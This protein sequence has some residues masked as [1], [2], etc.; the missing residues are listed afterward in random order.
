MGKVLTPEQQIDELRKLASPRLFRVL[1]LSL[2]SVGIVLLL[3]ASLYQIPIAAIF[4]GF[5]SFVS[6]AARWIQP[7]LH[8]AIKAWEKKDTVEG[9]IEIKKVYDSDHYTGTGQVRD[10]TWEFYFY[11][12]MNWEPEE[13]SYAAKF[14]FDGQNPW[15][16]LILLNDGILYPR[17]KPKRAKV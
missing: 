13:K 7:F 1:S 4:G 8:N 15:P 11:R 6:F 12:P 16:S 3:I 17:S 10:N 2:L 9:T 5:F 14:F